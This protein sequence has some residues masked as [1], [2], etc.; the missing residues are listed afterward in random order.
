[1]AIS[2]QPYKS[3]ILYTRVILQFSK[4]ERKFFFLLRRRNNELQLSGYI[5][6]YERFLNQHLKHGLYQIFDQT[7][8]HDLNSE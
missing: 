4:N 5:S 2:S 8:T 3:K 6:K 1:M 7:L